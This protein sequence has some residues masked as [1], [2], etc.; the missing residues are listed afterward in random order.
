MRLR[1]VIVFLLISCLCWADDLS[2]DNAQSYALEHII[3][4]IT[5]TIIERDGTVDEAEDIATNLADIAANP[6][7]INQA[8]PDDLLKLHFL[9]EEQIE[10]ILIYRDEHPLC[11]L[12]EL[13][14]IPGLKEWEYRYLAAFVYIGEKEPQK[15]TAHDIF[16][17]SKH[18]LN[19]RMDARQIESQK[20]PF[21]AAIKYRFRSMERVEAGLQAERD[22]REPLYYPKKIYGA[23]H[24]GGYLQLNKIFPYV[25]TIVLG[26]YRAGYG[27][28]LV[29][30]TG[31]SYGKTSYIANL[32]FGKNGLS[33]YAGVN[34]Y[35]FL[36][37]G[38]VTVEIGEAQLSGWYSYKKV[39]AN[40]QNGH[41]SSILQTGYH[42][43]ETEIA[44]KRTVGQ[45]VAG[46][47]FNWTHH[48]WRVGIT[49]QLTALSDTLQPKRNSYNTHYFSG[50]KQATIGL[51]SHYS[52]HRWMAFSEVATS[53]NTKWGLAALAGAKIRPIEDLYL[54][55]IGRY[56]SPW[57]DNLFAA[58]FGE[59]GRNQDE[60]GLYL[61]IEARQWKNWRIAGYA[62]F[63][64]FSGP[65]YRIPKAIQGCEL[66]GEAEYSDQ[67]WRSLLRVKYKYKYDQ[68]ATLRYQSGW[69]DGEWNICADINGTIYRVYNDGSIP[70]LGGAIAAQVGYHFKQVP[71]VVQTRAE[72]FLIPDW[73]NRIYLYENDVLGAFS[74]PAIYGKGGRWYVNARYKMSEHW[75]LYLRI[76]ETVFAHDWV[77]KKSLDSASRTDIHLLVRM[78]Y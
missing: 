64:G 10:R 67:H 22:P 52:G 28:G 47:N 56:Y 39:D 29:T 61:G 70:T 11:S 60:Y 44:H 68:K 2:I 6:I 58:A 16:T 8:T 42:R 35:N 31:I 21:Y 51:Y 18:E 5:S 75:S 76:A 27:L 65:K 55:A 73:N 71:I 24:W 72:A 32:N 33:K 45:H 38:G 36:R 30:S 53:S 63:F 1:L 62:D 57:Y 13:Q 77:V 12:Y 74:I 9:S 3:E 46:F 59:N 43:T 54:I 14:L 25:K 50:T 69:S 78:S 15:I 17:Y 20:D 4:Q 40:L 26:D 7:N 49:S 37:G 23:D 41:F 19:I 66:Q 48:A 34:E